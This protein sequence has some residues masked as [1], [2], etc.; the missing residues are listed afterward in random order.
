MMPHELPAQFSNPCGYHFINLP[1]CFVGL[2]SIPSFILLGSTLITYHPC[3][4][5]SPLRYMSNHL[6]R[7]L[8]VVADR[9]ALPEANLNVE[10]KALPSHLVNTFEMCINVQCFTSV[11]GPLHSPSQLP[12][13]LLQKSFCKALCV[14]SCELFVYSLKSGRTHLTVTWK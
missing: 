10:A 12:A 3:L 8:G 11:E 5:I 7:W 6:L 14:F 9:Y 13:F 4:I 1:F 2:T